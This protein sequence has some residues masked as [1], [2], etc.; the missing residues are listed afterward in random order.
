MVHSAWRGVEWYGMVGYGRVW[1]AVLCCA[2]AAPVLCR[3][4]LFRVVLQYDVSYCC[5]YMFERVAVL[6][7]V[8]MYAV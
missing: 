3:A 2:S 5:G 4:V 7:C 1:Y 6:I 8:R